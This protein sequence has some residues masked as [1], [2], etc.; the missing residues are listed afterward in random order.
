MQNSSFGTFNFVEDYKNSFINAKIQIIIEK[1]IVF[2]RKMLTLHQRI[3]KQLH[4]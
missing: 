3:P 1:S 2:D 4:I